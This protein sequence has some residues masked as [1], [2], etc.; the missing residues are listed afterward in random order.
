M[1]S[2]YRSTAR[3]RVNLPV[4]HEA[5][6]PIVQINTQWLQVISKKIPSLCHDSNSNPGFLYP[7]SRLG[8]IISTFITSEPSRRQEP[9]Q[10]APSPIPQRSPWDGAHE[11]WGFEDKPAAGA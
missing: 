4:N 6:W 1:L 9:V 5:P 10:E 11:E 8:V 2:R 7:H 3:P